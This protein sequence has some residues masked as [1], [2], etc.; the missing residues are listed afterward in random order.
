MTIAELT[1]EQRL[2]IFEKMLRIRRFE[3]MVIQLH[4]E[5]GFASHYH[6]Y[7]G[8]E[9][10]GT[11]VVAALEDGDQIATTHRNHGHILARGGDPAAALAEILG[12]ETG[13]NGGRG[14]TLHLCDAAKGFL[15]TSAV[16]GGCIGIA[17][18]AAYGLKRAGKGNTSVAFFGDGSLE[19]GITFEAMN[20]AALWSLPVLYICENNSGKA[21]GIAGGGYPSS[22]IAAKELTGV[23]ASLGIESRVVDGR[24]VDSV[25]ALTCE[26]MDAC[27]KG[28]GPFFIETVTDRW[29]GSRPLWPALLTGA[30]D[31]SMAWRDNLPGGEYADWYQSHDPILGFARDLQKR[32]AA[33]I[34]YLTE[35]DRSITQEIEAGA[36]FAR[37]S[38]LPNRAI[39]L[40]GGFA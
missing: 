21:P 16:V 24:D 19:E 11:A 28:K 18:G 13:M 40:E 31:I 30:T 7:I 12:R 3:E 35:A 1:D 2:E 15:S 9:A 25:Y 33:T 14:G 27:R 6:L 23:P 20:M 4:G 38:P 22:T 37:T 8:Q 36:E 10:T 39:A 5:G 34:E 29:P 17:T 26:A 32:G